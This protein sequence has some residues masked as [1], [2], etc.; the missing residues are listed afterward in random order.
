M[1]LGEGSIEGGSRG[2][3]ESLGFRVRGGPNIDP[4]ILQ[5]ILWGH[6][7]R[8]PSVSLYEPDMTP[9]KGTPNFEKPLP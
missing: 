4:S 8:S 1:N 2:T 3:W 7:K 5:S 6:P 9:F